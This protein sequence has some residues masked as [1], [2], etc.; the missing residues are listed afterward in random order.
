MPTDIR[1]AFAL[2]F[3]MQKKILLQKEMDNFR[4][5]VMISNCSISLYRL[6]SARKVVYTLDEMKLVY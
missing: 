2:M 5:K 6:N 3:Q 4:F 1:L